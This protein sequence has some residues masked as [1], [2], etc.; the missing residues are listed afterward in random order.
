MPTGR[1]AG[2][3]VPR[4]EELTVARSSAAS[5]P[6]RSDTS[7]GP[8]RLRA[9]EQGRPADARRGRRLPAVAARRAAGHRPTPGTDDGDPQVRADDEPFAP[10]PSRSPPTRMS[11]SW[12]SS[13]STPARSRPGSYV[14]NPTKGKRERIGRILR[15]HANHREEIDDVYAGDIAAAVGLK[16]T[17]TGDTL[18]DPTPDHAGVDHVPGAG[19]L[20][21]H[22]AED[23][24][25]PGQDG[26]G[27]PAPG[28]RGPDLPRN[29][30]EETD[31]TLIAGMG[32]LHL[33]V[34]VDRM[35]REF[36]VEANVG[37]PQVAYRETIRQ[38]ARA[39]DASSARPAATASTATPSSGS[40]PS[41]RAAATSSSTRSS[42]ARS[43]GNTSSRSTRASARRS[44][45]ASSRRADGRRQG[46]AVRR[47]V[48]RGRLVGDG[49]QD[50][51]FHGDQ[52]RGRTRPARSS[53]SRS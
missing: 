44:S 9:Q 5:A 7:S 12:P 34:I 25:R 53:S 14:L 1:R 50:R 18:C 42:A 36:K 8:L 46:H 40:S 30:D 27:A 28:R 17:F 51:R 10:S 35:M 37:Q 24:G 3:Q 32:E 6:P 38:A 41:R 33:D 16:D 29:S 39:T 21:R 22:R 15:M 43:R 49:V 26:R 48:P 2:R 13:A 47:V 4:G 31:Q 45:R 19:D 23:Q 20:G 11:A 52:G